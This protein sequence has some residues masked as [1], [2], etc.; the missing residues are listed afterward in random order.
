MSAPETGGPDRSAPPPR[1]PLRPFRFPPTHRRSLSNGLQV[2]V[3]EVREFPVV[4]L[5]VS[6]PASGTDEAP[7]LAGVASLTADLL[8][9]GAAGRSGL[10]I[11]AELEGLG[12][13]ED[14]GASWDATYVGFTA[15]RTRVQP[16][17]RVLADLVRRP[18][19]PLAEV[20]RVRGQRLASVAQRRADPGLLANEAALRFVYAPGSPY[21][22]ALS[23]TARSL[24]ALTRE[25]VRRF[26]A[27]RYLPAGSTLLAA[28]DL[29]ADE[30]VEIAEACFGDWAG[31]P[32]PSREPE[33]RARDDA[34]RVVL[35]DRPGSVQ[36]ELRVGQVGVARTHP[37][38]YPL[39]VMNQILGGGFSSRLNLS[40]R[41]RYGYTYGLHSTFAMRR[42][43]GPFLVSTAVQPESA[44]ASVREI[45]REVGRIR[46]APVSAEEL[47]DVRSYLAGVFPLRLETTVGVA[48]RLSSIAVYGL[49]DDY[50]DRY[51]ENVLAVTAGDVL[52][53]AREHL[54]PELMVATVVGDASQLR[55]A[56][57]E[58]GEVRVV[59]PEELE[60]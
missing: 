9:A 10:E 11:A 20:D 46:E 38:F 33:V 52:R 36:T 34:P 23:G 51:R 26:H 6:I 44:A 57:E 50:F 40:L 39:T 42:R 49:P 47:D 8:D 41:E 24:E 13:L 14:T 1:G 5:G 59:Q 22:R 54:D 53:V 28:G 3:A 43:P 60:A 2:L 56:L 19:F 18:D 48:A 21:A 17:A 55:T 35:V 32:D 7:E 31:A 45:F 25:D 4:S 30:A 27:A 58:F 12:V 15:L 16:A 37:D 29:S